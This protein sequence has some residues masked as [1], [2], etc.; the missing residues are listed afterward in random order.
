[1]GPTMRRKRASLACKRALDIAVAGSLLTLG[2]PLHLGAGLLVLIG[3]GRPVLY[4]QR[5]AGVD[6]QEFE[7]LKF[8]TME[9][10]TTPPPAQGQVGL[11]HPLVTRTGR[12]LRRFKI[13]EL[14][15]LVS[16]L[17]GDMSLVGP[18]PTLVEQVETY[19]PHQ[20]RRLMMRPGLTGWAQVN[21]NVSL[22]WPDRILLDLWYV[23]H[24][25]LR[26]D[27][28]IL[29]RTV[30]VILR[31]ERVDPRALERAREHADRSRR[32]S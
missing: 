11:E 21:G 31:G 30:G 9:V 13:D 27:L 10:H 24:W 17:R 26:L 2:A 4:R 12:V 18:R 22:S 16:V 32:R 19:D 29:A 5:R 1:M 15:Q 25:S 3:D 20:R 6:G 8:R 14:P 28:L 7:L 23:D